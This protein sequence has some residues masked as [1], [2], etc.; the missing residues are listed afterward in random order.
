MP[1]CRYFAKSVHTLL[2][3]YVL[4]I[5]KYVV[6]QIIPL[7]HIRQKVTFL[8]LPRQTKLIVLK[9]AIRGLFLSLFW[10]FLYSWEEQ[11]LN[12]NSANDWIRTEDLCCRKQRLYQLSHNHC[13][14]K[15]IVWSIV[16]S[17][18]GENKNCLTSKLSKILCTC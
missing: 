10:F 13:P 7:Q 6:V 4:I 12:V 17:K 8:F 14:I 15:C 2:V 18:R 16:G 5:I 1:K 11:M 9:W 3:Q